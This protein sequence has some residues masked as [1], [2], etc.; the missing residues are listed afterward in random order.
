[1]KCPICN[2]KTEKNGIHKLFNTDILTCI[3]CGYSF[4]KEHL[5]NK[6]NTLS[7]Q[8]DNSDSFGA[9][10][11]RNSYYLKI[12]LKIKESEKINNILEIGTPKDYDF[13]KKIH[14]S[15]SKIKIYSHDIIK[16]KYPEYINFYSNKED[17]IKERI[18][19][20]FCIHTLEH[21][22]AYHLKTFVD[23]CKIVSEKYIFEVPCCENRQRILKSSAQPHYSFF[24]EKSIKIL[25]GEDHKFLKTNEVL[26][27]NNLS[28]KIY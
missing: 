16:N 3:Q 18:D 13:L 24:T 4:E 11:N 5:V 15:D 1:M 7:Q 9:N 22:P 6:N 14:K 23:F 12:L 20:L 21:I 2:S 28:L 8:V 19:L 17:L 26:K 10:K 27:F 25:F